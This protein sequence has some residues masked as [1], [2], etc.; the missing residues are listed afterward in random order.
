MLQN[1]DG[2]AFH[3]SL[4]HAMLCFKIQKLD[5]E[6]EFHIKYVESKNKRSFIF[7]TKMMFFYFLQNVLEKYKHMFYN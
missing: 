3:I 2:S 6:A 4:Y 7:C 5:G 1:V